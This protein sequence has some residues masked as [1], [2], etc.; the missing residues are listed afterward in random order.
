MRAGEGCAVRQRVPALPRAA[1]TPAGAP[2]PGRAPPPGTGVVVVTCPPAPSRALPAVPGTG[3]SRTSWRTAGK[4]PLSPLPTPRGSGCFGD[5]AILYRWE[6][7]ILEM[8]LL[9]PSP[10]RRSRGLPV[11]PRGAEH[12]P[13]LTRRAPSASRPAEP[14]D[15]PDTPC[16]EGRKSLWVP[17][18]AEHRQPAPRHLRGE[19]APTAREA[20]PQ[21]GLGSALT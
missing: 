1:R 9:S 2:F 16:Q 12:T 20:S 14:G 19:A 21:R 5:K 18:S 7:F 10:P 6:M 4:A 8:E 11:T 15:S 17:V 13:A 3:G